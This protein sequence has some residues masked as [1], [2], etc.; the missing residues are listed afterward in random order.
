MTKS[1]TIIVPRAQIPII[2]L[3]ASRT[4]RILTPVIIFGT[5]VFLLLCVV[6]GIFLCVRL[7]GEVGGERHREKES[8]GTALRVGTAFVGVGCFFT[9]L[10]LIL[11]LTNSIQ[12]APIGFVRPPELKLHGYSFV[13]ARVTLVC[14]MISLIISSIIVS[15]AKVCV[16]GS[17][18]CLVQI[19][20]VVISAIGFISIGIILTALE[21]CQYPFQ[22]PTRSSI[23]PGT[24]NCRVSSFGDDLVDSNFTSL[25]PSAAN[26]LSQAQFRSVSTSAS[27]S[28]ET[29]PSLHDDYLFMGN[30]K[31]EWERNQSLAL[32]NARIKSEVNVRRK[33]VPN[34]TVELKLPKEE[35]PSEMI[36]M[37]GEFPEEKSTIVQNL[38]TIAS[39]SSASPLPASSTT[40]PPT[41]VSSEVKPKSKGWGIG[42]S[43]LMRNTGTESDT[44]EKCI[45]HSDS[46]ISLGKNNITEC[47]T[48]GNCTQ[49]PSSTRQ[50]TI[51]PVTQRVGKQRN[52]TPS[53]SISDVAMRSPLSTMRT[54][55]SPDIAIKPK[56]ALVPT[57]VPSSLDRISPRKPPIT[58][59]LPI[60]VLNEMMVRRPSIPPSPTRMPKPVTSE[61][62]PLPPKHITPLKRKPMES[63]VTKP[64]PKSWKDSLPV[65]GGSFEIERK[66]VATTKEVIS[67]KTQSPAAKS[68]P[69]SK[70]SEKRPSLKSWKDSLPIRGG[71][72]ET[73]RSSA[74]I[75][76]VFPNISRGFNENKPSTTTSP[77]PTPLKAK[78]NHENK[79]YTQIT[80]KSPNTAVVIKKKSTEMKIPGAFIEC[81]KSDSS[82]RPTSREIKVPGAYI[83]SSFTSSLAEKEKVS[84]DKTQEEESIPRK[85]PQGVRPLKLRPKVKMSEKTKIVGNNGKEKWEEKEKETANSASVEKMK[86]REKFKGVVDERESLYVPAPRGPRPFRRKLFGRLNGGVVGGDGDGDGDHGDGVPGR[87]GWEGVLPLRRLSLGEVSSG[88]GHL[89]E[90]CI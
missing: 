22:L 84:I 12:N 9:T 49:A 19:G 4:Q 64:P 38:S 87:M 72:F 80:T 17:H 61:H 68:T 66:P 85:K 14:W 59:P 24:V 36:S 77:K 47:G 25:N 32:A 82:E 62:V 46:A 50:S 81:T 41:P 20:G 57:T 31:E 86:Q 35:S 27:T 60:A 28:H 44:N 52:V 51:P 6:G 71:S 90:D 29:I 34:N 2:S 48:C 67:N 8:V 5:L 26:I 30:E 73:E 39:P 33:P 3:R 18:E 45:T 70:P 76:D 1:H 16:P 63:K 56:V 65:R 13:V 53:S 69:R 58:Q 75:R 89:W 7:F 88:M 79:T 55:E 23:L 83:D 43:Y 11:H 74:T 54:A 37:P 42:W 21:A 40:I 10:Y 15:K 78:K